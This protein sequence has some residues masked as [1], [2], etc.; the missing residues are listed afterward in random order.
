MILVSKHE[1]G[2][3]LREPLS[4]LTKYKTT[5]TPKINILMNIKMFNFGV[6]VVLYLRW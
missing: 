5:V 6:N 4:I 3:K 2:E 1:D